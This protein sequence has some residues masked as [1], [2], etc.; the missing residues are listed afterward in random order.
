MS[1]PVEAIPL[2]RLAIAFSPVIVVLYFQYRWSL[3][4]STQLYALVRMLVQL[5]LIGYVLSFIFAAEQAPIVLAV[6]LI[7]VI[8]SSWIGLRTV[9]THRSK[10]FAYALIA[11]VAGGG[12]TLVVVTQGV[13]GITPWYKPNYLIPLA[14]MVFSGA[15]NGVSLSAERL[16]A[17]LKRGDGYEQARSVAYRAA[18]IP[19]TNSLF[20]VG[21]VSLPGMM[22]GQILSGVAPPIAARYQIMVMFMLLGAT[23]ISAACFLVIS[24]PVFIR[25]FVKEDSVTQH[26]VKQDPVK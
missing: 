6:L 7:M 26:S 25:H 17:E 20:A 22:T 2:T 16:S 13:L 3:G 12:L 14:G 5:L 4:V 10:L 21:L 11:T 18:L 8:S 24:R 15:M 1:D 23:G 19:V 9:E